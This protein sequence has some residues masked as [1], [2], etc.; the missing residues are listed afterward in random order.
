MRWHV[1]LLALYLMLALEAGLRLLFAMPGPQGVSP[2]FLLIL[3][4]YVGLNAPP[5][6]VA[7]A[8]LVIGLMADLSPV[9]PGDAGGQAMLIGPCCLAYFV[10]GMMLVRL[11]G[12]VFRRSP[13]A[14]AALVLAVGTVIHVTVVLVFT[15]RGWFTW[16][17]FGGDGG[18][19]IAGWSFAGQFARRLLEVAYTAVL[20]VPLGML[21][22]RVE[23]WWGFVPVR[24]MSRSRRAFGH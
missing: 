24:N 15:F 21:L 4:V 16:G 20:A 13:L 2:S 10:G 8:M 1:F 18:D 12:M 23:P 17:V 11:R 3:A 14:M 19:A 22:N 7:W 5:T 6:T 9:G